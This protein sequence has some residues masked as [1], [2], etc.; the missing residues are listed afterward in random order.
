VQRA[1]VV[2]ETSQ[3]ESSS[4]DSSEESSDEE[5]ETEIQLPARPKPVKSSKSVE[6]SVES[7]NENSKHQSNNE[8]TGKWQ[9][10]GFKDYKIPKKAPTVMVNSTLVSATESSDRKRSSTHRSTESTSSKRRKTRFEPAIE[11]LSPSISQP[12]LVQIPAV[13]ASNSSCSNTCSS[14]STPTQQQCTTPTSE[15]SCVTQVNIYGLVFYK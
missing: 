1:H 6:M 5:S 10:V 14:S 7:S 12:T 11:Q 8:L 15:S 13:Q 9:K 3:S 2:E 4:S